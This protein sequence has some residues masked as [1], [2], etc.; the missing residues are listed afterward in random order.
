MFFFAA[1]KIVAYLD[2]TLYWQLLCFENS[3]SVSST[4]IRSS[5]TMSLVRAEDMKKLF[6]NIS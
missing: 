2:V 4:E 5:Q 3:S 6:V 1:L